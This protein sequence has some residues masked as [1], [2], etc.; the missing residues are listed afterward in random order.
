MDSK[1]DRQEKASQDPQEKASQD[2]QEK[3]SQDPQEKASQAQASY[4]IGTSLSPKSFVQFTK[5]VLSGINDPASYDPSAEYSLLRAEPGMDSKSVRAMKMAKKGHRILGPQGQWWKSKLMEQMNVFVKDIVAVKRKLDIAALKQEL[6]KTEAEA[7]ARDIGLLAKAISHIRRA[8]QAEEL[9]EATTQVRKADEYV[10]E[11]LRRVD[12][13]LRGMEYL[14][15]IVAIALLESW[16]ARGDPMAGFVSTK[17]VEEVMENFQTET[18]PAFVPAET[19]DHAITALQQDLSQPSSNPQLPR[20]T[21]TPAVFLPPH[22]IINSMS[23]PGDEGTTTPS[24]IPQAIEAWKARQVEKQKRDSTSASHLTA[25]DGREQHKRELRD[26]APRM[27]PV[28]FYPPPP[29][30]SQVP[31]RMHR[32]TS[33]S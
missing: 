25:V 32:Q 15:D 18:L 26:E 3:A 24:L 27:E 23:L 8:I 10:L 29:N 19:T 1:Q 28:F 33:D 12:L 2:P 14:T 9:F 21:Q 11:V 22:S 4:P 5:H 17:M 6:D 7:N 20:M 30:G 31:I 13:S 16:S